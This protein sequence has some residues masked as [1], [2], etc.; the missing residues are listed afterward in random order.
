MA[1]LLLQV[2]GR[3]TSHADRTTITIT[4]GHGEYHRTGHALT[5]IGAF[6]A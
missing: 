6:F 3:Q 1:P 5:R 4:S 2:I